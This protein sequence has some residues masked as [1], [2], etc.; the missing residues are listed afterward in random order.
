MSSHPEAVR[1]FPFTAVA[2]EDAPL[3]VLRCHPR[4]EARHDSEY[5]PFGENGRAYVPCA[6]AETRRET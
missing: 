2:P 5:D 6:A 4:P 1:C 3:F